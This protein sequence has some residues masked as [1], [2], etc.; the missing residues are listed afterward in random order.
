MKTKLKSL[1]ETLMLSLMFLQPSAHADSLSTDAI[2]NLPIDAAWELFTS[3]GGLQSL[4]YTQAKANMQLGGEWQASGG[5]AALGKLNEQILSVDP[6]H[7]LSFKAAGSQSN[8]QWTVLYFT[9]MGNAM[10]QLRW[11]EFFPPAQQASV[12]AHQQ[13]VRKQFELLIRR[14]APECHVCKQERERQEVK[15]K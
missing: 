6:Q 5:D 11:L 10:T 8:E 9:A 1:L 13:Q 14:F 4:G 7:M 12:S 2:I 3:E 15:H